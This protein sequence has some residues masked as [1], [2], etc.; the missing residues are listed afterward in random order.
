MRLVCISNFHFPPAPQCICVDVT[1]NG[2]IGFAGSV[3]KHCYFVSQ[4]SIFLNF[5]RHLTHSATLI[6]WKFPGKIS[7][8]H[9]WWWC[10]S[11][12]IYQTWSFQAYFPS[13]SGEKESRFTLLLIS[14]QQSILID[15][16]LKFDC[17]GHNFNI[18]N[19]K[20]TNDFD[21][22]QFKRPRINNLIRDQF[23][24]FQVLK[25]AIGTLL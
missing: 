16:I 13:Q 15:L 19:D 2:H 4:D 20:S 18:F 3:Q 21:F 17:L 7:P 11:L 5:A 10:R 24:M 9:I 25:Q 1:H 23:C 8:W 22:L 14:A 12:F 6:Q